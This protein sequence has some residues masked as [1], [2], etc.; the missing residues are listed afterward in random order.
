[1][2]VQGTFHLTPDIVLRLQWDR[3]W[4]FKFLVQSLEVPPATPTRRLTNWKSVPA[5]AWLLCKDISFHFWPR[6]SFSPTPPALFRFRTVWVLLSDNWHR[7]SI[8]CGVWLLKPMWEFRNVRSIS[9]SYRS[10]YWHTGITKSAGGHSER[11]EVWVSCHFS[12]LYSNYCKMMHT[13]ETCHSQHEYQTVRLN[14]LSHRLVQG[15]GV[16]GAGIF[17]CSWSRHL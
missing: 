15:S 6:L 7:A 11:W 13:H 5:D 12:Q 3:A 14:A 8:T 10:C 17:T 16:A 1:M 2:V 9:V 4:H